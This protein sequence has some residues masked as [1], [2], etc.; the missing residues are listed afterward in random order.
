[1]SLG[2]SDE[3]ST[4]NGHNELN[5][6]DYLNSLLCLTCW[7]LNDFVFLCNVFLYDTHPHCSVKLALRNE[8]CSTRSDIY[9]INVYSVGYIA[10]ELYLYV[11]RIISYYSHCLRSGYTKQRIQSVIATIVRHM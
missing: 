11:Y 10:N 9:N 7:K 5:I 3:E 2:H 4:G 8:E 1:M 6:N